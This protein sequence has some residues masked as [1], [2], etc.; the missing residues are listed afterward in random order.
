M[1]QYTVVPPNSRLIGAFQKKPKKTQELNQKIDWSES[2]S[3]KVIEND[4][5]FC[6]L[7]LEHSFRNHELEVLASWIKRNGHKKFF[8]N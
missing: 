2:D 1:I 8:A 3:R 6:H 5:D 4:S 7:L